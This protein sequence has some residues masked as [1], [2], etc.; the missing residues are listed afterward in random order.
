MMVKS[1]TLPLAPV[2]AFELFTSR[3]GEWWP[4]DRRHS[5]DP[6]SEI[7]LLETGRFYERA[8]DGREVELGQVR[9]W[10][11]PHRILLDFFV[12]TGREKPTE[13]EI[14]FVAREGGTEVTVI[15]RPKPESE[16]LWAERAPRYERSWDSVLAALSRAAA[17][18]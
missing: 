12:A 3:T 5:Q 9:C 1:V 7:F 17:W 14:T 4:I 13:V 8:R 15:H 6:A 2:A 11:R 10:Q 18:R 16:D